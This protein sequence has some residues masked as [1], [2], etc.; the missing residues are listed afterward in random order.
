MK[1]ILFLFAVDDMV[2]LE[3]DWEANVELG[4]KGV[5]GGEGATC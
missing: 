4:G 3:S 2:S 1:I 5:H